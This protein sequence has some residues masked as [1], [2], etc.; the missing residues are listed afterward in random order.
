MPKVTIVNQKKEIEVPA[1][2]NLREELRKNGIEL[3]RYPRRGSQVI[4]VK[5][6]NRIAAGKE[7]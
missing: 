3:K 6:L 5:L 4:D 2:A 7:S 1:G